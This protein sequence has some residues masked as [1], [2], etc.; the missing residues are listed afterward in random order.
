MKNVSIISLILILTIMSFS[1]A[2]CEQKSQMEKDAE[3][4]A[5]AIDKAFQ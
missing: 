1:A 4:A 2:G 3:E 5:K